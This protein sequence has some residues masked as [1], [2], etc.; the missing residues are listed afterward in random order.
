MEV[1]GGFI[2]EQRFERN[3]V[4]IQARS[5]LP[6]GQLLPFS[7]AVAD[8]GLVAGQQ[9]VPVGAQAALLPDD[10]AVAFR[11]VRH[12]DV[13]AHPQRAAAQ[14]ADGGTAGGHDRGIGNHRVDGIDDD[15]G[16]A[17]V[18]G[19]HRRIQHDHVGAGQHGAAPALLQ[20]FQPVVLAGENHFAPVDIDPAELAAIAVNAQRTVGEAHVPNG[21]PGPLEFNGF[22]GETQVLDIHES[23]LHREESHGSEG[24]GGHKERAAGLGGP[25][26]NHRLVGFSAVRGRPPHRLVGVVHLIN[27][28]VDV[29]LIGGIEVHVLKQVG[30]GQFRCRGIEA[31]V[32]IAADGQR[33]NI[34]GPRFIV[35]VVLERAVAQA[36]IGIGHIPDVGVGQQ[37]DAPARPGTAG[38][39]FAA[40]Q[41]QVAVP[42][43][44]S[45]SGRGFRNARPG[46]PVVKRVFQTRHFVAC[47]AAARAPDQ[48]DAAVGDAAGHGRNR[49]E[50]AV[51]VALAG[52]PGAAVKPDVATAPVGRQF[53]A[54]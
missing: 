1:A 35:E 15:A 9:V 44:F 39:D 48:V 49:Q 40:G 12:E 43:I 33:I 6:V 52:L 53:V 4:G 22:A 41:L 46:T 17:L 18:R 24:I 54:P 26:D 13:V 42:D 31:Q 11:A 23:G 27:A 37:E 14:L 16:I 29:D 19:I 45:R 30:Q 2:L 28:G 21:Q 10:D 47:D 38:P 8:P 7:V 3:A 32:G 50:P 5:R 34:V 51:G 20:P 25:A 36:E